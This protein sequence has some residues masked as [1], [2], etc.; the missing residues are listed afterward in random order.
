MWT[1]ALAFSTSLPAAVTSRGLLLLMDAAGELGIVRFEIPSVALASIVL[2][3]AAIV[4][5]DGMIGFP[6]DGEVADAD[7]SYVRGMLRRRRTEEV[8]SRI[9]TLKRLPLCPVSPR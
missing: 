7:E 3:L 4:G 5:S 2:L 1:Y 6:K 8:A 9:S